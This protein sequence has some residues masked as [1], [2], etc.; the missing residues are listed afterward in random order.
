MIKLLM[1]M[2]AWLIYAYLWL[3]CYKEI[4]E[5]LIKDDYVKSSRDMKSVFS[6]VIMSIWPIIIILGIIIQKREGDK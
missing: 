2:I 5:I 6:F 3:W 4:R 1:I